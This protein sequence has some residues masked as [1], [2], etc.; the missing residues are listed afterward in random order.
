MIKFLQIIILLYL[1]NRIFFQV[2]KKINFQTIL[3]ILF[4]ILVFSFLFYN[5]L[6]YLDNDLGWHLR[7]GEQII[8]EGA[9]P[10]FDQFDYTLEGKEWVDHEWLLN[11]ITFGFMII[12]A[13]LP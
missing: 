5:S 3:L 12:S 2:I 8:G 7:V 6:S 13:S 9:V 4:Y 1:M 10:T 11:L